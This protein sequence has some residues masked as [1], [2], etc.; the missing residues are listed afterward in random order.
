MDGDNSHETDDDT[1]IRPSIFK[2]NRGLSGFDAPQSRISRARVQ[3][4]GKFRNRVFVAAGGIQ[5]FS[6]PTDCI[7]IARAH[8]DDAAILKSQLK[9]FD[10]LSGDEGSI[11]DGHTL[12]RVLVRG[13]VHLAA[14][15]AVRI[16]VSRPIVNPEMQVCAQRR[17]HVHEAG[18]RQPSGD[19]VLLPVERGVVDVYGSPVALPQVFDGYAVGGREGRCGVHDLD[20]AAAAS[21]GLVDQRDPFGGHGA[22]ARKRN[23]RDVAAVIADFDDRRHIREPAQF[24]FGYRS[25]VGFGHALT[26]PAQQ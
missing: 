26:D 1:I 21:F 15:Q 4:D 22:A 11:D 10:T 20:T 9:S 14:R 12:G 19:S 13:D 25:E 2:A 3:S 16:L 23:F 5:Q 7:R 8:L 6:E 24:V 17:G 18:M